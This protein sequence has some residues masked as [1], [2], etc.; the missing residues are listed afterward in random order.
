MKEKVEFYDITG[1][2]NTFEGVRNHDGS[3]EGKAYRLDRT[4]SVYYE[5]QMKENRVRHGYG[6]YYDDD[7]SLCYEGYWSEDKRH[8]RGKV[9]AKDGSIEYEGFFD[10]DIPIDYYNAFLLLDGRF[11]RVTEL[12]DGY[13]ELYYQNSSRMYSGYFKDNR[14]HDQGTRHCPSGNIQYEGEWNQGTYYGFGKEYYENGNLRYE[15]LWK[16]SV[17]NGFCRLYLENGVLKFV[18]DLLDGKHCGFGIMFYD[19]GEL[20]YVGVF[21]QDWFISE[22]REYY[23]NGKLIFEGEFNKGPRK[24]YGPRYYVKGK[25]YYETGQLRYEGDML[26]RFPVRYGGVGRSQRID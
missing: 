3:L 23:R 26:K 24:Y 5:G 21:E 18:G 11:I 2:I 6:K 12:E 19:T 17:G 25:L 9:Y 10:N 1:E 14:F 22:G 15:G 8:G 7:G 20:Q 4:H 16:K 13:H